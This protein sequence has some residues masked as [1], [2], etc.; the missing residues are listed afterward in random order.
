[1]P[2]YNLSVNGQ[3]VNVDAPADLGP[4][5]EEPPRARRLVV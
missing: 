2:N 4:V 3:T 5:H 1:M